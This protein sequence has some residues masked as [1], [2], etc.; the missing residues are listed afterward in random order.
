MIEEL[1][2][3]AAGNSYCGLSLKAAY[4]LPN[5]KIEYYDALMAYLLGGNTSADRFTLQRLIID[6]KEVL[7]SYPLFSNKAYLLML[8]YLYWEQN[9][10]VEHYKNESKVSLYR[11]LLIRLQSS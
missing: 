8:D 3:I 5:L 4:D 6:L 7:S 10:I 9:T 2:S 11:L 1:E